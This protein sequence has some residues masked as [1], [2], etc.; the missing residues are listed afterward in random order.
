MMALQE[1]VEND[2][3]QTFANITPQELFILLGIRAQFKIRIT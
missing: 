2:T 3:V 1:P